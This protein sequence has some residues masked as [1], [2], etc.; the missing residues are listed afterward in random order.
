LQ[1][2]IDWLQKHIGK[3]DEELEQRLRASDVWRV[4]DDLLR[5]IPG[6]GKVTAQTMLAKCPELG[7]LGPARDR[8]PWLA[9]RRC[10]R[11]A[12]HGSGIA[13]AIAQPQKNQQ[14]RAYWRLILQ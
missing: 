9:R 11:S 14:W 1:Q 3:I 6:V 12:V 13:Q 4:K 7:T 10:T 8:G 2:H 5:G